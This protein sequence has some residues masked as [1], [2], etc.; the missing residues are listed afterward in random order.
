M[1]H[2]NY[3]HGWNCGCNETP[4]ASKGA[5]YGIGIPALVAGGLA[6]LNQ[7]GGGLGGIIGGGNA[8]NAANAIIAK[9]DAEIAEL[10]AERYSDN[11][12]ETQANRLLVNYLKPYGDAIAE[13]KANEARMQAEIDCL[14]KTGELREE[15]LK[16]EIQLARQEAQCCCEKNANAVNALAATVGAITTVKIA[17]TALPTTTAA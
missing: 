10:K 9:K 12:A 16:K 7:N 3:N 14:K 17:S 15:L 8:A 1:Y 5:A 11:A 13:T 2:T 4:Y 6:L